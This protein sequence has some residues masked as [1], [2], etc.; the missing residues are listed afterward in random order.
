MPNAKQ[1]TSN[2]KGDNLSVK[3]F[4]AKGDGITSDTAAIN[5]AIKA[6]APGKTLRF[7][8]GTYLIDYPGTGAECLISK[9]PINMV[10]ETGSL[11][12]V[13]A[14]VPG[15]VDVLRLIAPV[16]GPGLNYRID[17]MYMAPASGTPARYGLNIDVTLA[18]I[19]QSSFTGMRIEQFG[20][21]SMAIIFPT[22]TGDGFFTSQFRSCYFGGGIFA[23]YLG[24][25]VS[26]W[27][28][29]FYG[30]NLGVDLSIVDGAHQTGFYQCNGTAAKGFLALRRGD[31]VAIRDCNLEGISV[32]AGA[33]EPAVVHIQGSPPRDISISAAVASASPTVITS[34]AHGMSP[35]AAI[36]MVLSGATGSW[37]TLNGPRSATYIDVDH[38]SVP[39]VSTGF[40]ALAGTVTATI[41]PIPSMNVQMSG[42]C[43]TTLSILRSI[44]IDWAQDAYIENNWTNMGLQP[45][46]DA[47][48]KIRVTAN[49]LRTRLGRHIYLNPV[50]FFDAWNYL[51][52]STSTIYDTWDSEG[53]GA[54]GIPPAYR[55]FDKRTPVF[56]HGAQL[57]LQGANSSGYID[58]VIG[59]PNT[60]CTSAGHPFSA[61][62]VGQS[63]AVVAGSGF[64]GQTVKIVSVAG[65]V[66]TCSQPL[67]AIGS[68]GGVATATGRVTYAGIASYLRNGTPGAEVGDLA[69]NVMNAGAVVQAGRFTAEGGLTTGYTA[70]G[71]GVFT[72]PTPIGAGAVPTVASLVGVLAAGANSAS[73]IA[74]AATL[75]TVPTVLFVY[76][77][78]P[79]GFEIWT[80]PS[81]GAGPSKHFSV[82]GLGVTTLFAPAIPPGVTQMGL[83]LEA[84]YGSGTSGESIDFCINTNPA[85]RII[86]RAPG[87]IEFWT[88]ANSITTQP[89][90]MVMIDTVGI[91]I[92][93]GS[94]WVAIGSAPTGAAGGDLT[95]TYPNPTLAAAGTAGAQLPIVTTD[96]KG[97]VTSS[98]ALALTDIPAGIA[99]TG[100]GATTLI[101]LA[102]LT[103]GGT[104]GSISFNASGV[105]VG[106][107]NPT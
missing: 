53:D 26:W 99:R 34:V 27:H 62:N 47:D 29:T 8:K 103:A 64:I 6:T 25:S 72:A 83:S 68:T 18:P 43:I 100:G 22:T 31:N 5:S 42:N 50:G 101:P 91:K 97:R 106:W 60:T 21:N 85:A 51:D 78:E 71:L 19:F 35:G 82:D 58:L 102:K 2:F 17:G 55:V 93:S 48:K 76:R 39:F 52:E 61:A 86:C 33:A 73:G 81:T 77:I 24:D 94:A 4:K 49:A 46:V 45:L 28:C 41:M 96:A 54:D 44:Q 3:M 1:S 70:A 38:F 14:S 30:D 63:M 104:N 87:S 75:T 57:L 36:A 15:T 69:I 37:I 16:G 23:K 9:K 20:T 84:A 11:L 74:L 79:G 107:V 32:T 89:T 10:F 105:L 90:P 92:W 56:S 88:T 98:A 95:G 66:A 67:G 13:A 65:V 12:K 80:S 7:P 40:G 59:T